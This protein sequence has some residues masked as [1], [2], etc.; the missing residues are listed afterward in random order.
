M[1][2]DLNEEYMEDKLPIDEFLSEDDEEEE[3]DEEFVQE[4][5]SLDE[6]IDAEISKGEPSSPEKIEKA[7]V[8]GFEVPEGNQ[9]GVQRTI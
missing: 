8:L 2:D 5:P 3:F 6:T 9:T 4:G 7:R 1:E